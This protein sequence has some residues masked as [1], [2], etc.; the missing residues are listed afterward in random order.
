MKFTKIQLEEVKKLRSLLTNIQ[1]YDHLTVNFK[2]D[3]SYT[4]FRMALYQLKMFKT[5]LLRWT[6]S[7]KKYLQDH[8]KEKGNKEIASDLSTGQRIFTVKHINKQMKIQQLKRTPEDLHKI[9]EKHKANGV[10]KNASAKI[11]ANGTRYYPEGFIKVMVSHG[12]PAMMIKI[13]GIFV[14]YLRYRY[15]QLYGDIPKGYK[16]YPKDY[17]FRNIADD[18]ITAKPATGHNSEERKKYQQFY[19]QYFDELSQLK[20][21][22]IELPKLEAPAEPQSNLISVRIGK[23]IIKVKPGTDIESVKQKF[24]LRSEPSNFQQMNANMRL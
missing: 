16:V 24:L 2:L 12:R 3:T 21:K 6:L 14:H 17:N 9:K 15:C 22:I 7:E 18:N 20:P 1:L 23:M 11:K 19:R 8:Y 13:N 4:S 5:N 10:Y